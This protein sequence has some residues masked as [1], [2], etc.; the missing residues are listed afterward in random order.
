[1]T[2]A[3]LQQERWVRWGH[4][5]KPNKVVL[6]LYSFFDLIGDFVPMY[7]T[8]FTWIGRTAMATW[9]RIG[10]SIMILVNLLLMAG[11]IYLSVHH[12]YK[13]CVRVGYYGIDA[14]VAVG[15]FELLFVYCSQVIQSAYKNGKKQGVM[16]WLGF[17]AGFAFVVTS[18]YTGMADTKLAKA[19]GVSMPCLLLV[20]KGVLAYQFKKEDRRAKKEDRRGKK[21]PWWDR[22]CFWREKDVTSSSEPSGENQSPTPASAGGIS[23]SQ[24]VTSSNEMPGEKTPIPPEETTS[25]QIA[26]NK[27]SSVKIAT[28]TT[29]DK[30]TSGNI[31]STATSKKKITSKGSST[32]GKKKTT[33]R[34]NTN[35]SEKVVS[36]KDRDAEIA[37]IIEVA[38]KI[39]R[40]EGRANCGR[41]RLMKEADCRENH[42]KCA[43]EKIDQL[44]KEGLLEDGLS[45]AGENKSPASPE[46]AGENKSPTPAP[47][48]EEISPVDEKSPAPATGE[49]IPPATSDEISPVDDVKS[50]APVAGEESAV[51]SQEEISPAKDSPEES[52]VDENTSAPIASQP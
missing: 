20:M 1:M 27:N 44:I 39:V 11:I 26:S 34:K 50:P 43:L 38:K 46:Q 40:T 8:L 14:W 30:V 18:N 4:K 10:Q 19:I 15:V 28:S 23:T 24:S 45:P 41:G 32:T 48:G 6:K 3:D 9:K 37:R 47:G 5:R 13:L 25:H 36:M 42:A 51:T 12:S 21:V 52:P 33:S 35:A 31:T 22:L 2:T 7:R 16:P 49:K 17:L 29:S